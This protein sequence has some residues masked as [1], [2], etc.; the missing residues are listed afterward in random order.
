VAD[1]GFPREAEHMLNGAAV[2]RLSHILRSVQK[3]QHSIGYM[4]D[5]DGAHFSR[6]LHCLAS[7][8][9]MEHALGAHGRDQIASQLDL[10]AAYGGIGLQSLESSADEEFL[11]S[12]VVISASLKAFFRNADLQVYTTIAET[13]KALDN[14]VGTQSC[15]TTQGIMEVY[16]R[17]ADLRVFLSEEESLV[18]IQLVRG[19]KLV[20]VLGRSSPGA[21]DPSPEALILPEPRSMGGYIS[22]PCKHE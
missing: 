17:S 6:W 3:N 11:G 7:S 18:A 21:L 10:P 8:E 22:A 5:M 19:H 14:M 2:P 1:A 15:P 12:F 13:L 20:E 16:E 9:D 4:K